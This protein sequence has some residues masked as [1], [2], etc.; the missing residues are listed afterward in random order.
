MVRLKN[1]V[2]R[3]SFGFRLDVDLVKKLKKLAVDKDMAVNIL[4][5]EGLQELLRKHN[6]IK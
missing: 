5:E 3:K 1:E 2:E 6:I 4:I